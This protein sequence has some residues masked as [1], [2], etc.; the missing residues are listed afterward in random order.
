[1]ITPDKNIREE[2]EEQ[3]PQY[4]VGLLSRREKDHLIERGLVG[5][6][7]WYVDRSQSTRTWNA[8]RS[9]DWR[10]FRTDHSPEM[11]NLMEGFYAIEQYVPDYTVKSIH[12]VRKSY[13]RS[14]F[15]IRWGSEEEKHADAWL[16]TLLFSRHRS[17]EWVEDYKNSLRNKE[18]MLPWDDALHMSCYV[19]IQER[20][21]QVNYVNTALAAGGHNSNPVFA[22]DTDPILEQVSKKLVIDEAA[23]YSFFLEVLRMY[24]YYY[25]A[26]TLDALFDTIKHFTMP[27]LDLTGYGAEFSEALY[28]YGIYG[29]RNYANDV[30][31]FAMNN[32]SIQD[33][34]ALEHGIKRSR[35]VPDE[36]GNF[37]ETAFFDSLDYDEVETNVKKLFGKIE[38]YEQEI[39]L[40]EVY[41]TEFIPS[42]MKNKIQNSKK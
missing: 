12:Q 4:P 21:T 22:G 36:D 2:L 9:F 29:P 25:P 41:P 6:Y 31:R 42:G 39:G 33:R 30:L 3:R 11:N 5:L 27:A 7:R 24:L 1:M 34:R 32:L 20:A 38:R 18:W 8:D 37:R 28:R 16:N 26:Q 17:P 14:H 10:A 19:V 15:Q 13:G 23:H 35:Q 40:D